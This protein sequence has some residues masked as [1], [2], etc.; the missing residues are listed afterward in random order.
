MYESTKE[1][2]HLQVNGMSRRSL[3]SARLFVSLVVDSPASITPL[4]LG[5]CIGVFFLLA[6]YQHGKMVMVLRAEGR[7]EEQMK[8]QPVVRM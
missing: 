3:R 5:M 4:S 7:V 6:V 8:L 1:S 2:R